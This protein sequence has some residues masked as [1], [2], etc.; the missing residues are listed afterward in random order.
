[1]I[2]APHATLPTSATELECE[3]SGFLDLLTTL[4]EVRL[5]L[6]AGAFTLFRRTRFGNFRPLRPGL[7]RDEHIGL[8]LD[9]G[10]IRRICF[11]RGSTPGAF[12]LAF[13]DAGFALS[14][15]VGG[16]KRDLA[17][18]RAYVA[19]HPCRE[20]SYDSVRREGAAAWLDEGLS[21]PHQGTGRVWHNRLVHDR[22]GGTVAVAL[23]SGFLGITS[24]FL[25]R[26][27]D[28]DGAI[29]RVSDA[30]GLHVLHFRSEAAPESFPAPGNLLSSPRLTHPR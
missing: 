13:D 9:P 11:L 7:W 2:A 1:M 12:E 5:V 6:R 30:T 4:S 24:R 19:D 28:R 16:T 10:R 26:F 27:I 23:R 22:I 25:P 14:F 15:P 20:V 17:A 18:V 3:A 29:L 21:H 8:Y